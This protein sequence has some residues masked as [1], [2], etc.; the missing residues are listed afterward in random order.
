MTY[1]ETLDFL[2]GSLADFQRVGADAY[3]PG[4]E[5]V[6]I[7]NNYLGNPDRKFKTIHVAGTNGKGSVSHILAS[8][9]QAAGYRTGLFTSPHLKDFRERIR[10]NG[11]PIPEAEVVKFT[12]GHRDKMVAMGLSFFEMTVGMALSYFAREKVDIAIIEVGLGGRLDAT[13]IIRPVLGI[14]TNI[15]LDHTSLLGDSI[16][17]I[18]A[19]KGGII[20]PSVPTVIGEHDYESD[21]VFKNIAMERNGNLFFA[22]DIYHVA[23]ARHED[24]CQIF[25]IEE[26]GGGGTGIEVSLDLLGHYQSRNIITVMAA[27]NILNRTASIKTDIPAVLK[28]CRSVVASTSL[29]GRWQILGSEPLTVCD[30]GHNEHGIRQVVRQIKEQRYGRLFMV[31]GF[32]SDKDVAKMLSILPCEAYFIFTRASIERAMPA[33]VLA[34]KAAEYGLCG[35]AIS[36][37][38]AALSRACELATPNDM[39]F[40]GGSNFV[41]AEILP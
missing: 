19:E 2:F 20:K 5:R 34:L 41:V 39:I 24:D 21:A 30:T 31:I 32:V 14:I 36:D 4:L 17:A 35:E 40:I 8:I 25:T 16:E 12:A 27:L 18:A 15:G 26:R 23:G 6:E 28:G 13:N 10:V 9:L 29:L 7:F 11:R 38:G 1:G 22:Q 3:K 37:A 33:E